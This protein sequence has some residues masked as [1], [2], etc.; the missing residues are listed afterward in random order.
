MTRPIAAAAAVVTS[1]ET[2]V[3]VATGVVEWAAAAVVV[4]VAVGAHEHSKHKHSK[5][6][7]GKATFGQPSR[8]SVL[9]A[10][11]LRG[12][13]LRLT[14]WTMSHHHCKKLALQGLDEYEKR[15]GK[16]ANAHIL[17]IM[18]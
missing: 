7:Q 15:Y 10:W 12:V 16:R 17:L 18:A 8:K 5:H 6:E 1:A 2:T 14:M 13:M 3:G 4:A 11:T 9:G